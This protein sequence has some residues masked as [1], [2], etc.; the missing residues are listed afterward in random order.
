MNKNVVSI[1]NHFKGDRNST[2]NFEIRVDY[3]MMFSQYY[4]YVKQDT[5]TGMRFLAV[6]RSGGLKSLKAYLPDDLVEA[7][8]VP[9]GNAIKDT[10]LFWAGELKHEVDGE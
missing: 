9:L 1:E 4:A 2:R 3:A 7:A 5:E 8:S 6:A 10:M